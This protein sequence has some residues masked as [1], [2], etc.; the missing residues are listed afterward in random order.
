MQKFIIISEN[1][2]MK[3]IKTDKPAAL[4]IGIGNSGRS[5]DGAGWLFADMAAHLPNLHCE[6]RYQLQIED[7]ELVSRYD[8]VFFADA[9]HIALPDGFEIK[10]IKAAGHFYYSSHLQSPETILYLAR[11][12]Y[13]RNPVAYTIALEGDNWSLGTE[14][15]PVVKHHLQAA[16]TYFEKQ[17]LPADDCPVS[18]IRT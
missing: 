13:D 16:Y 9:S 17:L 11:M 4:L 14:A 12:L 1:S 6:Y 8:R 2:L 5:D 3:N 18:F 15:G 7:A 10:R